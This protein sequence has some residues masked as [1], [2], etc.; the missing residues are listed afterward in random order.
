[1]SQDSG[2]SAL[3]PSGLEIAMQWAE[4]PAEHM[5][6]ALDALEPQLRREHEARTLQL[7]SEYQLALAEVR[8]RE[9]TAKRA[10]HLYLTGLVTGFMISVAMLTGA[11][12]VGVNDQPWLAAML[13][14]PSVIALATL[15]VL[16]RNEGGGIQAVAASQRAALSAAQQPPAV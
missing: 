3:R 6:I 4:L 7:Q 10:H 12:L 9:A 13:S 8:A 2:T 5:K 1:M 14:G 11:V 16:R 15:F